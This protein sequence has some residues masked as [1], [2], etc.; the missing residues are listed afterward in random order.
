MFNVAVVGNFVCGIGTLINDAGCAICWKDKSAL[1]VCRGAGVVKGTFFL[2]NFLFRRVTLPEP[3]TR[4]TYW[5]YHFTQWLVLF[6]PIYWGVGH[7]ISKLSPTASGSGLLVCSNKRS[8]RTVWRIGNM[9]L[10]S[11]WL[12]RVWYLDQ[13]CYDIGELHVEVNQCS[14][15]P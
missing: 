9:G 10:K 15:N 12:V 6:C 3:S 2:R 14:I 11:T 13:G 7:L 1:M 4:T 8:C 5:L